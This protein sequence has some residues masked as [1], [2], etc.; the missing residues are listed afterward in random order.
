MAFQEKQYL[1]KPL[2]DILEGKSS[3]LNR[4]HLKM[5]RFMS[6]A[7]IPLV[8]DVFCPAIILLASLFVLI[9][10]YYAYDNFDVHYNPIIHFLWAMYY[11]FVVSQ[12][13]YSFIIGFGIAIGFSIY[14]K[15][16]FNEV[17][18]LFKSNNNMTILK[19]IL[20]HKLLCDQVEETN[21]LISIHLTVPFL[22]MTL[23]WDVAFYL[24]LYGQSL[25][26]RFITALL[27]SFLLAGSFFSFCCGALFVSE[28]HK[29]YV[30]INSLMINRRLSFKIKLKVSFYCFKY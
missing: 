15:F 30:R 29:P 19:A 4:K 14:I 18:K 23:A 16:R 17:N 9:S 8:F 1:I 12:L 21:N 28:A 22:A 6:N 10:M 27:S 5:L 3:C 7:I 2:V 26:L 24:T 25:A 11:C 13:M 20:K